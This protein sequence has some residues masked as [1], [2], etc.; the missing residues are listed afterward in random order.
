MEIVFSIPPEEVKG[1]VRS[2]LIQK[3][4]SVILALVVCIPMEITDK[5]AVF[6]LLDI[7]SLNKFESYL[8]IDA[9]LIIL[10][11]VLLI[12]TY[13]GFTRLYN[14]FQITVN[15]QGI[16]RYCVQILQMDRF[17]Q[18]NSMYFD[19]VDVTRYKESS[20]WLIVYSGAQKIVIPKQIEQYEK[21]K[22]ISADKTRG[23]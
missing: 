8:I 1:I 4:T 14:S 9:F 10:C 18:Y 5:R 12:I 11:T 2:V 3:C 20:R 22:T 16:E 7:Q 19:W 17:N 21:L 6:H 13:G 15:E 23:S